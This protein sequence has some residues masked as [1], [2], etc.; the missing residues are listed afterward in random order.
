MLQTVAKPEPHALSSALKTDIVRFH[1][2]VEAFENRPIH[3]LDSVER[4]I[5]IPDDVLVS[6][7]KIRSE[8][9]I[10]HWVSSPGRRRRMSILCEEV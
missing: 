10:G 6:E 4:T 1:K 9:N 3:L 7:V 2:A 8:P 5:T